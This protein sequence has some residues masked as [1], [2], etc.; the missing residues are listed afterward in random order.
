MA[1]PLDLEQYLSAVREQL[2][3]KYHLKLHA[4]KYALSIVRRC[5]GEQK[6]VEACASEL[7]GNHRVS[8]QPK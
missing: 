4:I 3:R 6:S 1:G 8:H 5:H 7:A 2:R